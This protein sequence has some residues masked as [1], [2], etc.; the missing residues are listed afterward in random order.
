M[1]NR[2]EGRGGS[3][4]NEEGNWWGKSLQN[5]EA[6]SWEWAETLHQD[7]REIRQAPEGDRCKET[8]ERESEGR[9]TYVKNF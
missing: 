2:R 4:S 3:S 1:K 7:L 8:W 6:M 5:A 9:V